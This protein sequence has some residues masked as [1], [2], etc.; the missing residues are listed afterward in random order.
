MLTQMLL[1]NDFPEGH[2]VL[3]MALTPEQVAELLVQGIE[4]EKFLI[5][6]SSSAD[7]ALRAKADNYDEWLNS[8]SFP[9]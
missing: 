6:D 9:A 8:I 5:L 2:P 4:D 3:S 1:S 7:E